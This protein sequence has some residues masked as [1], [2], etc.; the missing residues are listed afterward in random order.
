MF[1][2]SMVRLEPLKDKKLKLSAK[3]L[4]IYLNQVKENQR[5]FG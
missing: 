2:V 4:M 1:S 3:H 5:C